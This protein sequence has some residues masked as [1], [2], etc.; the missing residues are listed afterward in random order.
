MSNERKYDCNNPADQ[1]EIANKHEISQST[2]EDYH[3][4]FWGTA[5]PLHA[6]TSITWATINNLIQHANCNTHRL[7]F[8]MDENDT[9]N[10]DVTVTLVEM[11]ETTVYYSIPLFKG[12]RQ[13]MNAERFEFFKARNAENEYDIIFKAI[14]AGTVK[15]YDLSNE[16]P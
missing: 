1:L 2:F 15:F 12:I 13:L 16:Y 8:E 3:T 4:N 11:L 14:G 9:S 5:S 7:R 6:P 10:N